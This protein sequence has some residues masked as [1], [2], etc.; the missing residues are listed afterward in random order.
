MNSDN[1]KV[2]RVIAAQGLATI[3]FFFFTHGAHA[4]TAP[5]RVHAAH[6]AT[7]TQL[8]RP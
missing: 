5:T 6:P 2:R 7:P 1:D 3:A 4:A 8:R